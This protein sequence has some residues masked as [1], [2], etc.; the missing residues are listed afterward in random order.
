MCGQDRKSGSIRQFPRPSDLGLS[1]RPRQDSN[2]RTRLR[3]AAL[4]PLSYGGWGN[5]K[6]ISRQSWGVP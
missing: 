6:R 3:R 1:G 4:Y 2:L 5:E